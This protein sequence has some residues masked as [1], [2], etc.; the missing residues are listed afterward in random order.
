MAINYY[1]TVLGVAVQIMTMVL[2]V[3]IGSDMLSTFYDRMNKSMLNFEELGVML[4]FCMAL[5]M[6]V[7]RVPPLV[8]G[9]ITGSGIGS[10][11]GIG[12]F[13]AG[14]V[15]G[16]AVGAA[17][18]AAGAASMAGSA[19][20]GG[21]ANIAGGGSAIKAAFE[22]AQATMASG[23]DMPSLGDSKAGSGSS[24]DSSTGSTPFAQAAGFG[25]DS[26]GGSVVQATRVAAGTAG[27]LAKGVGS[28]AADNFKT[29]TAQTAGGRLATS[30]RESSP[31]F[32]GN[33]L[34]GDNGPDI[35]NQGE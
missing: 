10:A 7:N 19:V 29:R 28:M 24:G 35:H 9:I 26:S 13:G 34:T 2:L 22:Q 3:G 12:S 25:S 17:G 23:G 1:K 8:A 32:K 31:S 21:A 27:N 14:A 11:G 15:V 6:L 18:M 33:S 16:A 5:L 20:M 30:I 4:V